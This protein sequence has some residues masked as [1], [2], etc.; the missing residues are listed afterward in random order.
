MTEVVYCAADGKDY[1]GIAIEEKF[2]YG[3]R[4][5]DTVHYAPS[6]VDNEWE[7]PDRSK[8]MAALA[9]WQPR[10]ATVLDWER[11]SQLDEVLS[12]AGEAARHVSEAILIIPKVRGGVKCLPWEVNGI[13]VRLAFSYPTGHGEADFDILTEMINWPHGIHVL[14]GP[15]HAQLAIKAGR[16]KL[17]RRR[18]PQPD[19][20]TAA[21]DVRSVDC[22]YHLFLAN[23]GLLW[24]GNPDGTWFEH[25]SIRE[26]NNGE[27]WG[28]GS[29]SANANYE[30]FRQSCENIIKAWRA[31]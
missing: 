13:P 3:A 24:R 23:K 6:F 11:W 12:W 2:T 14:G 29:G 27:R 17:P 7:R 15:P 1:A 19:M 10:L 16:L 26:V 5:P 22:N 4:L 21:L 18:T 25:V 30:A 8:Y 28:D 31:S 20:F 9:E